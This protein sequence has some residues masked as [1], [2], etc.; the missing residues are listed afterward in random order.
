MLAEAKDEADRRRQTAEEDIEILHGE[1]RARE[2]ELLERAEAQVEE[3][4]RQR[5]TIAAQLEE[6]RKTLAAAMK[7]L[8]AGETT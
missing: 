5:D 7:P 4:A 1:A 2:Q 8:G 6:L 3:L